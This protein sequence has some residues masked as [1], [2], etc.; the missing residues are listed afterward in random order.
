MSQE[1]DKVINKGTGAGGANTNKNGLAFEAKTD[2]ENMLLE[3]GFVKKEIDKK[4]YYLEWENIVY[5]KQN[6]FKQYMSSTFKIDD[7][8]KKP[9]EC[10]IIKDEDNKYTVKVLE[11]KNQNCDGSVEEKLLLGN[12]FKRIYEMMLESDTYKF[13][14]DYA[15]CMSSFLKTKITSDAPKYKIINK[16]F[17]QDNITL[18]YGDDSDYFDKVLEWIGID[19]VFE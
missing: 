6:G 10:F 12:P 11:K 18:L 1:C 14:I 2:I 17:Q 5:V 8:F 9:D 16:L 13:T 3:A 19:I 4:Y 7:I 15:F